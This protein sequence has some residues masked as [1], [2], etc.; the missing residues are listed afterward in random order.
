MTSGVEVGTVATGWR[1]AGERRRKTV[2]FDTFDIVD[3]EQWEET[4]NAEINVLF[5]KVLLLCA[6]VV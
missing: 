5:S 2:P 4:W 3:A 6:F 1:L